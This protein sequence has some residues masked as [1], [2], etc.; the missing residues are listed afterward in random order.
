MRTRRW[1]KSNGVAVILAFAVQIG[2]GAGFKMFAQRLPS[3]ESSRAPLLTS[4][5]ADT[6]RLQVRQLRLMDLLESLQRGDTA[7]LDGT[8]TGATW[9]STDEASKQR[10][11]C[12]SIGSAVAAARLRSTTPTSTSLALLPIYFDNVRILDS[13]GVGFARM[14]VRFVSSSGVESV[15]FVSLTYADS[16]PRWIHVDGLLAAVCEIASASTP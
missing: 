15:F 16:E 12:Q 9:A 11:Q 13:A 8:F 5:P 10:A 2:S 1:L 6:I 7:H 14:Q 3:P 4:L